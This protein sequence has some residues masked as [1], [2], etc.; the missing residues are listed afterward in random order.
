MKKILKE[1]GD[2][3]WGVVVVIFSD[4]SEIGVNRKGSLDDQSS[5]TSA[6]GSQKKSSGMERICWEAGLR[7]LP[8]FG[9]S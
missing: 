8:G 2:E 6:G 3:R 7:V 4:E 5:M 1:K 9:G